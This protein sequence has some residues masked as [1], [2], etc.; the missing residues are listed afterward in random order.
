M[1][2]ERVEQHAMLALEKLHGQHDDLEVTIEKIADVVKYMDYGLLA[3]PGLVINESLV[4][5]GRIPAVEE[6][7]TW[8]EKALSDG[9][10]QA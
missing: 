3:T 2:C 10:A 9:I 1:N 6:I 5:A 7:E 4:A 8:L